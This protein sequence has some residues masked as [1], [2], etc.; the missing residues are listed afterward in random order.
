MLMQMGKNNDLAGWG[1][2]SAWKGQARNQTDKNTGLALK[3]HAKLSVP[4]VTDRWS[5]ADSGARRMK[6]NQVL[7]TQLQHTSKL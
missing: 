6:Q 2:V 1:S 3:W 7:P 5:A 4:P